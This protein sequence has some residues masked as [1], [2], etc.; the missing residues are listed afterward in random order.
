MAGASAIQV[1]TAI[2]VDPLSPFKVIDGL[3]IFMEH[4]GVSCL[5]D[6]V[7]AANPHFAGPHKS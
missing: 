3:R 6:L 5:F 2:F 1:G 7:G 4:E